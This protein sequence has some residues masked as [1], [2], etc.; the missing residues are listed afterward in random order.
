MFYRFSFCFI[1]LE[2]VENLIWVVM[3]VFWIEVY[4]CFE[5]WIVFFVSK[6][7]CKENKMVVELL[8]LVSLFLELKFEMY[9]FFFL[10]CVDLK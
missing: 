2:Y 4:C 9:V 7:F 3:L 5:N 8:I 6:W 1:L 10:E